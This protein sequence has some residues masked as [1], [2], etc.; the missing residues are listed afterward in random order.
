MTDGPTLSVYQFKKVDGVFIDCFAITTGRK[1]DPSP[2]EVFEGDWIRRETIG[3][4]DADIRRVTEFLSEA[5]RD[6]DARGVY[7]CGGK[8]LTADLRRR[9][10]L[11]EHCY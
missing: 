10:K 4:T 8:Y 1:P 2:P 5:R 11:P 7:V 6:L 9:Y 3:S